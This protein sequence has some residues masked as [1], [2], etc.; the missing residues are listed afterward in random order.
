MAFSDFEESVQQGRPVYFLKVVRGPKAW[1]YTNVDQDIEFDGKM[2]LAVALGIPDIQ[3]TGEARSQQLSISLPANAALSQYLDSLSPTSEIAV[4]IRK[5]HMVE[6][7]DTGEFTA[8][9]PADT[10]VVWVGTMTSFGRPSIVERRLNCDSIA[11]SMQR[12]GL[13]L[14]WSRTCP[15]VLYERGCFVDKAAFAVPLTNF[16]V[17]DNVT[18]TAD[19]LAVDTSTPYTI[20]VSDVGN[21]LPMWATCPTLRGS[22]Q[23]G[24][25]YNST[26]GGYELQYDEVHNANEG[27]WMKR[28]FRVSSANNLVF[29]A[30]TRYLNYGQSAF[31]LMTD[32]DGVGGIQVDIQDGNVFRICKSRNYASCK[33]VLAVHASTSI[34][35]LVAG[36]W[37]K[38]RIE[39]NV[40]GTTQEIVAELRNAS[41]V[42]LGTV[43]YTG[44]FKLGPYCGMSN[45]HEADAATLWLTYYRNITVD[46]E[47][48]LS[49]F[50]FAGGFIEWESEPGVLERTGIEDASVPGAVSVFGST[51]GMENGSNFVAYPGCDRTALV[52]DVRFANLLN[53]GGVNHLQGKSPFSFSPVF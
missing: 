46:A 10:P 31:L 38:V 16:E 48:V 43:S 41:D 37:Y 3:Y 7:L 45:G 12:G 25:D 24:V 33:F 47:G 17:V 42:L 51:R 6:N 23:I 53:F 19:E 4:F 11:L 20:G 9:L 36:I 15:H 29:Q 30:E 27:A 32:L 13:R 34:T 28:N 39:I 44:T 2:Y 14:S 8:P 26:I 35:P 50:P 21:N 49:G 22:L 52:C 5:G 1:Y 40:T 18:V